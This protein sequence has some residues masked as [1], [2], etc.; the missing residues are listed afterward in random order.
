LAQRQPIPFKGGCNMEQ[1]GVW[2]RRHVAGVGEGARRSAGDS[3]QTA[4]AQERRLR[5]VGGSDAPRGRV[6]TRIGE[7]RG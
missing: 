2:G 1:W 3:S 7:G 6:P 5:V 4:G